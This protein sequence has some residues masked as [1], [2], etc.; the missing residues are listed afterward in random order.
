MF[1]AK[2]SGPFVQ[3]KLN[4]IRIELAEIE[5]CLLAVCKEAAVVQ[6]MEDSQT[7]APELKRPFSL[8]PL[9]FQQFYC[10]QS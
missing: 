6:A 1:V 2:K 10:M 9:V 3:V 5:A 8:L 7:L 4:G